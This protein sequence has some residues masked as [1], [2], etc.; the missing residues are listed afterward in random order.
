MTSIRVAQPQPSSGVRKRP[1]P[2]PSH[3]RATQAIPALA[4][5][6]T[7]AYVGKFGLAPAMTHPLLAAPLLETQHNVETGAGT[8][9]KASG[10]CWIFSGLNMLRQHMLEDYGKSFQYS[11]N[12]V[13]YWD[14]VERARFY[15]DKMTELAYEPASAQRTLNLVENLYTDGGEWELFRNVVLKHGVVPS[16]AMPETELAGNSAAYMELLKTRVR[17]LGGLLHMKAQQ[18]AHATEL[19]AIKDR[20]MGE[21]RRVLD[22]ALGT[23]PASFLWKKPAPEK[24]KP[25]TANAPFL[26]LTPLQ[27]LAQNPV[28]LATLVH[29]TNFPNHPYNARIHV[30]DVNN[31]A[32]APGMLALNLPMAEFK[33]AVRNALRAGSSVLMSSEVKD[34]DCVNKVWALH[35]NRSGPLLGLDAGL[36]LGKGDRLRYRATGVAHGMLFTGCDDKDAVK[37]EGAPLSGAEAE[38]MQPLWRVENSWKDNARMYMTDAWVDEYVYGAVVDRRH[39]S[40]DARKLFNSRTTPDITVPAWDPFGRV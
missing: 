28:D 21:V 18:G 27:F 32:G 9:Q 38:L 7:A 30:E 6:P 34:R 23:P 3:Q 37:Y 14:K 8:D 19:Q 24:A 25:A 16:Y 35:A 22:A 13:A 39:L 17:E 11:Q 26:Q 40:A 1:T 29:I 5:T 31:V 10:R 15:F 12:Y 20:A 36:R 4:P 33:E 2:R